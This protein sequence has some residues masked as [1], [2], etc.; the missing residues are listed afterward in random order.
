MPEQMQRNGN[1]C[2][3]MAEWRCAPPKLARRQHAASLVVI[4]SVVRL[5][6]TASV[7]DGGIH[8]IREQSSTH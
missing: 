7:V 1:A 6:H 2:C 5:C 3:N 4:H 8:T